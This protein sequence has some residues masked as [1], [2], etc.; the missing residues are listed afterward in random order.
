LFNVVR[1]SDNSWK[2]LNLGRSTTSF[3]VQVVASERQSIDREIEES[4]DPLFRAPEL[5]DLYS[6]Y[7]ITEKIDVFALGCVMYWL[8]Y[9]RSAFEEELK[10]DQMNS[11]YA[12]PPEYETSDPVVNLLGSLM[13]AE[14]ERRVDCGEVW[15]TI[16]S[17][18]EKRKQ[19][20]SKPSFVKS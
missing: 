6:G 1:G 18:K 11:R 10:L 15:S 7:P 2:L 14:P 20:L 16:D 4:T 19:A 8:L 9:N 3:Y 13:E 12:I 5:L 17:I